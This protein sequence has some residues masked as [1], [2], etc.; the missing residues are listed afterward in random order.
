MNLKTFDE[1]LSKQVRP[2]VVEFWAPWCHPCKA[3]AP[4][5]SEAASKY[6]GKVDL[7]KINVDESPELAQSLRVMAVPTIIGYSS[8]KQR[9]RKTG[10]QSQTSIVKLF[11][12]LSDGK[13][14]LKQ[15]PAPASRIFRAAAGLGLIIGGIAYDNSVLLIILGVLVA[16]SAVY[17]R[18]PVYRAVS[19]WLKSR[20]SRKVAQQ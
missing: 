14:T 20:F 3:M 9:L 10:F 6:Q 16:F 17:D 15:G 13:I 8:G 18:C 4:F 5:L 2:I 1:K 19:G 12:E 7:I 11:A